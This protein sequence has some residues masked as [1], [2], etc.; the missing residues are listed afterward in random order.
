MPSWPAATVS[1][2]T[3]ANARRAGTFPFAAR[4]MSSG[5]TSGRF[6]APAGLG[7]CAG[8]ALPNVADDLRREA[9]Y[10][11]DHQHRMNY[12]KMRE[13]E[14]VI[15]YGMVEGAAKQ[16]QAR[17]CGPGMCW[18]RAGTETHDPHLLRHP[19]QPLLRD[20]ETGLQLAP[21]LKCL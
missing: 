13:E 17:L 10:C 7:A 11:R 19:Q 3:L 2:V 20:L 9:D 18:S 6:G 4:R 15:G 14:C 12:L 21:I 16:Y 8:Y 1:G 5:S